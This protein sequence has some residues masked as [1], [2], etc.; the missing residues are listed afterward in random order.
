MIVWIAAALTIFYALSSLALALLFATRLRIP[1]DLPLARVTLVLP[2][3]G[4]LPNIEDLLIALTDQ[5]LR[6][7][8]LIVAVEFNE[9]ILPI[10]GLRHWPSV[11][12]S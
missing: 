2:A 8:R 10:N 3:T 9:T 6:P 7:R 5:S 1:D 11:T 12:P 4:P